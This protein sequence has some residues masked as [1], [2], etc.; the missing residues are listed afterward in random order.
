MVGAGD[1]FLVCD[2]EEKIY[3]IIREEE[4]PERERGQ[5][6]L[7]SKEEIRSLSSLL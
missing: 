5:N 7:F 6:F 2:N 1:T 3:I 4:S